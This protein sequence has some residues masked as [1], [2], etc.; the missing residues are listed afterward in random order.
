[1]RDS[2]SR[3]AASSTLALLS[4]MARRMKARSR[5]R[6]GATAGEDRLRELLGLEHRS[7]FGHRHYPAQFVGELSFAQGRHLE[8]DDV[9]A[10]VEVLAELAPVAAES[11]LTRW[12]G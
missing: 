8:A 9:E 4:D 11:R 6:H 10:V 7:G 3:R 2:L 1:L 12:L 5:R